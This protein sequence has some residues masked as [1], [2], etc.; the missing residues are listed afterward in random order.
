MNNTATQDAF[1]IIREVGALAATPNISVDNVVKANK[2]ISDLLTKV[3]E[4]G[5]QKLTAS[6]VGLK[7]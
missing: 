7:L 6:S 1:A 4:P 5:V 2:I 3:I